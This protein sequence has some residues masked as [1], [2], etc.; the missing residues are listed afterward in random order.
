MEGSNKMSPNT[1]K[2]LN[3]EHEGFMEKLSRILG[4]RPRR[5]II[6]TIM[7][8]PGSI[9]QAWL[10][11]IAI[12]S[13][14]EY[15]RLS[16]AKRVEEASY[17]LRIARAL[18]HYIYTNI[19]PS[20]SVV[21]PQHGM[22]EL[23][24]ET[25][26]LGLIIDPNKEYPVTGDTY[27][28]LKKV[29][30]LRGRQAFTDSQHFKGNSEFKLEHILADV[31]LNDEISYLW[32]E[33]IIGPNLGDLF[34][35]LDFVISRGGKEDAKLFRSIEG[36]LADIAAN[37]VLYW[38]EHAPNLMDEPKDP[39]AVVKYY[40][41]NFIELVS[42]FPQFTDIRYSDEELENFKQALKTLEWNFIDY[43]KVV[44]NV[45]AT[46]RNMVIST[47]KI[48]IDSNRFMELFTENGGKRRVKRYALEEHLYFVDTP[49]K[50]SHALE[51][52]WEMDLTSEGTAKKSAVEHFVRKYESEGVHFTPEEK[53]LIGVFRAYRKAYLILS[54]YGVRNFEK[55]GSG[56]MS[57]VEFEEKEANHREY[58]NHLLTKGSELL[59]KLSKTIQKNQKESFSVFASALHR[60]GSYTKINYQGNTTT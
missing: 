18:T 11:P 26:A 6:N 35:N 48:N 57:K 53:L 44:R 33:F 41:R 22:D 37:R 4:Y 47:R 25:G 28:V 45:A 27:L 29:D 13:S 42:G 49:D 10:A 21:F 19:D 7:N 56:L 55:F 52:A 17:H 54:R 3:G 1:A 30:S 2:I 46:F 36:T 9:P 14:R 58:L 50:H 8:S 15:E 43:K 12:A 34:R 38:Q 39:S 24:T 20:K 16:D 51:D 32:K 60:L 5:D 23:V 31:P 40:K 59:N